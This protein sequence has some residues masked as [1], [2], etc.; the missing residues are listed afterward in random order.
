MNSQR[1]QIRTAL[2]RS[3]HNADSVTRVT[4]AKGPSFSNSR[5]R[6]PAC[7]ALQSRCIVTAA[8]LLV[9]LWGGLIPGV[10]GG[11]GGGSG[12]SGR[13]QPEQDA[14]PVDSVAPAGTAVAN[15]GTAAA[16]AA[17]VR[18]PN[19]QQGSSG[20]SGA[21]GSR[22]GGSGGSGASMTENDGDPN[23]FCNGM[24]T[25]MY[26][27]GFVSVFRAERGLEP[28]PVFLF[29]NWVLNTPG[30]FIFGCL[31][32]FG[33]AL[34]TELVNL[35]KSQ[36]AQS[37]Q[38]WLHGA[39]MMLG[40]A[41]M[42]LVMVYSIELALAVVAGLVIGRLMLGGGAAGARPYGRPAHGLAG[43]G[44]HPGSVAPYGPPNYAGGTPCCASEH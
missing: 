43:F 1:L 34:L 19:E 41:L 26:M 12:G 30:R 20:S 3:D 6:M 29:P 33:L 42:L 38:P 14:Q 23:A 11:S 40:Y 13:T 16:A 10:A 31:V 5:V 8:A 28:C 22:A 17:F 21:G 18:D 25:A 27:Q 37:M 39:G 44:V 32:A 24:G 35:M 4:Q 15:D 36:A 9:L 7:P 2:V